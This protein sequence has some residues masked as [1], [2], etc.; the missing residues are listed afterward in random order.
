MSDIIGIVGVLLVVIAYGLLQS[1]KLS[2][3]SKEYS[4]LNLIGSLLIMYSLFFTFNLSSFIIEIIWSGISVYGLIKN[5]K[6]KYV[7]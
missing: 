2:L 1:N 3:D 6:K 4:L 5:R 7:D